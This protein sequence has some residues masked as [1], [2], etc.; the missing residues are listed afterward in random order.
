MDGPWGSP[1]MAM[2][3][4]TDAIINQKPIKIFN[5]GDLER[6]FT[7]IDDVI[8]GIELI[9]K[10]EK[11]SEDYSLYNIGNSKPVQLL[12]FIEEIENQL[13]VKAKKEMLP[14]QAGDVKR[15]W[16]D[17]ESLKKEFEYQPKTSIK[18]G[19]SEFI[20]WYRNYYNK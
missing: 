16:A 10:T 1:G 17:V 6:D 8:D 3:L 7:Y 2:F 12:S 19:I 4:F 9:I 13:G 5:H 11:K 20:E 15:T 18:L 14:M